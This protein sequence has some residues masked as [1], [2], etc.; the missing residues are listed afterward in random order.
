LLQTDVLIIGGGA[1][2]LR[3]SIESRRRGSEVVLASKAPAGYSSSTLY[4]GGGFRAA[5]GGYSKERHF[6]E[7]IIGGKLLNDQELVRTLVLEA[8]DRLTELKEF[9][10]TVKPRDI[11]ISV[12]DGPLTPGKGLV[13]PMTEH[14]KALGVTF[15][16]N[17]T[18]IDLMVDDSAQGAVF[19]DSRNDKVF[20]VSSK[21]TILAT[22]GYSQL[23]ARTD[24]PVRVSGDGCA[25]AL[26][27]GATLAD[28][29]FTQFFP[30]GLA[31]EGKPAWLFPA[32]SGRLVNSLDE[33][34]LAKYRFNK[35]LSRAAVE[36]RDMLS[37]AMWTEIFEGRGSK[38][39]LIIDLSRTTNEDYLSNLAGIASFLSR[40]L[41]MKSPKIK[42]A[43]TAHF[44]MGG[45]KIDVNCETNIP[46]L[47]ACGEVS[48]GVHGANRLGG[49][50]LTEAMVFGARAGSRAAEWAEMNE[51]G[52][53]DES[54]VEDA[55]RLISNFKKGKHSIEEMRGRLKRE[56]WAKCGVIRDKERLTELLDH[57]AENR[58]VA[59]EARA[60]TSPD[61][62][63]ALELRNMFELA[64]AVASSALTREESRGAHY[65]LDFPKQRDDLWL[66]RIA[67]N[68]T[69]DKL[70]FNLLPVELKYFSTTDSVAFVGDG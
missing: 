26:R 2:G 17:V 68:K 31:E 65:R 45:V 38:E 46:G 44:T 40:S 55:E 21:A 24:N 23:F 52:T 36:D 9:G 39:T 32:L 8:P 27:A 41:D 48:S 4:S 49:N 30:I 11:G 13:S 3:S 58:A 62:M 57:I 66:K 56:N 47:F 29:E 12:S 5:L 18:A 6:E 16:E 25:M 61:V 51:H 1:A 53:L 19:Y 42:V 37:R 63:K 69:D 7:T 14:A 54:Y 60:T 15:L 34:I 59:D 28:L 33:D 35:P 64:E 20:S 22:G 67:V 70:S 10:V 43:P 50:A